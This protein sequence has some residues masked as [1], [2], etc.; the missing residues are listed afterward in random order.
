MLCATD[1]NV[2][3]N[4]KAEIAN[5]LFMNPPNAVQPTLIKAA[6]RHLNSSERRHN[7][8]HFALNLGTLVTS[9]Q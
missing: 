9:L 5:S 3:A 8:L 1:G 2:N 6:N 7:T 4:S